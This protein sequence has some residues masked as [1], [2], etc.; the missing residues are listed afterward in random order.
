M[1]DVVQ[2]TRE[3]HPD[4]TR[5]FR[6]A[7]NILGTAISDLVN[8]LNPRIVVLGGRLAAV[9]DFLFAGIREVVYRRSLPLATRKLEIVPS[10]L[11]EHAG[12]Y[13]LARLVLDD[14]YSPARITRLLDT[15]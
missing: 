9:D 13:G 1:G 8:V 11:A 14:V 6:R 2:L 12:V 3:G 15:R 7:M 4:A 10:T 5:L